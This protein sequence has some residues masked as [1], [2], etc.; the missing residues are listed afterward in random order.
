MGSHYAALVVAG[1]ATVTEIIL[2]VAAAAEGIIL[3]PEVLAIIGFV[4]AVDI[5]AGVWAI[6]AILDLAR[7]WTPNN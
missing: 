2:G 5:A 7:K 6:P 1:L 4:G 3:H